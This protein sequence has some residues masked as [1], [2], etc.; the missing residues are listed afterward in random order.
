[1]ISSVIGKIDALMVFFISDIALIMSFFCFEKVSSM[2]AR[3][4]SGNASYF[5]VTSFYM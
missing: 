1:M 3:L 2:L 4:L 5:R